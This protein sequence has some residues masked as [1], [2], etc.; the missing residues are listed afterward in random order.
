ML[1][2]AFPLTKLRIDPGGGPPDGPDLPWQRT[3]GPALAAEGARTA[4]PDQP[5]TVFI[6]RA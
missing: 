3:D 4:H 2:S 1:A 5:L 6:P